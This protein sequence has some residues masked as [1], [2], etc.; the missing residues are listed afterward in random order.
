MKIRVRWIPATIYILVMIFTASLGGLAGFSSFWISLFLPIYAVIAIIYLIISWNYYAWHQ[1]FSTSHPRKGESIHF[2]IRLSNDGLIPLC[3]GSCIYT[4]P[5]KENS[6]SL[7]IGIIPGTKLTEIYETEICC[8][9]RGTYIAGIKSIKLSTPLHILETNITIMPQQFYVYPELYELDDSIEKYA[10]STGSA[11]PTGGRGSSDNSIFEYT[12]PL[13]EEIPEARIS[14]KKWAATGIPT[15]I[16]SGQARSRGISI[17]LDLFPC[18][19]IQTKT[20]ISDEE[21]LA[22]EDLIMS[23]AFSV[24][25]YLVLHDIPV[26]FF[27]GGTQKGQLIDS[28]EIFWNLYERSTGIFFDD[29]TIPL[30]SFTGDT[31]SILFSTRPIADLYSEYEHAL[32]SGNEPHV[33]LCPPKSRFESENE[34]A[35]LIREQKVAAGSHSLFYVA[36]VMN[37]KKEITDA[38]KH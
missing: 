34:H 19:K 35:E 25:Q 13:R 10:I 28:K 37:C 14:W 15:T 27:T 1:E 29:E 20:P 5:G 8:P 32:H 18:D 21:K 38:F 26:T 23:A 31:K 22:A 33:L 12:M 17:V 2:S 3:G 9:Y 4:M 7:P 30:S 6:L 36:D 16:V 24:M 11:I